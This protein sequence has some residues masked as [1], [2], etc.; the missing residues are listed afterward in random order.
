MR[1]LINATFKDLFV[2]EKKK[3]PGGST[4]YSGVLE[5][6]PITVWIDYAGMGMQLL[7]GV[8]IRMKRD[9]SSPLG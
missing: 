2:T 7:Y 4:G 5:G 6:T 1:N 8:S 3:L 9:A